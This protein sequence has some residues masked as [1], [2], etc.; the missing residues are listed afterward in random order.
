M[1]KPTLN[2]DIIKQSLID[3][4]KNDNK[5]I[6]LCE[7][8]SSNT[9]IGYGLC[10]I[11]NNMINLDTVK[12]NPAFF[13]NEVNAALVFEVCRHYLNDLEYLYVCDGERNIRHQSNYQDFLV[14]V[15]GF[16][17]AYCRLHIIYHPLIRPIVACL[18]PFRKVIGYIKN[19]NGFF[20]NLHC[21][22]MQEQ[23]SRDSLK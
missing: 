1:Y 17:R 10:S 19:S 12:I 20:Y 7:D 3:A 16:R 4:S 11:N 13:R 5:D 15:L 9:I 14:T 8:I 18:Y 6:W 2:K 21:L 22:L 23:Y